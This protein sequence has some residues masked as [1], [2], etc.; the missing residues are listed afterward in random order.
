VGDVAVQI[1]ALA[2]LSPGTPVDINGFNQVEGMVEL[3]EALTLADIDALE[4]EADQ[5]GSS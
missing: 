2:R 5:A 3:A 1:E 4:A